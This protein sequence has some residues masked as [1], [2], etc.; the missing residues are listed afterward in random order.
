MKK[1]LALLALALVLSLMAHH[2]RSNTT[3]ANP[4][5]RTTQHTTKI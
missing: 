5:F 1:A 2:S 4:G 3:S